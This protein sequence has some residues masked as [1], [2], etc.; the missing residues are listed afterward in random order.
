MLIDILGKFLESTG[1]AEITIGQ[2]VMILVSFIL[3]YLAIKKD[4][5][6]FY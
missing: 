1:L 6:P 4:L 2:I 5:N 3:L